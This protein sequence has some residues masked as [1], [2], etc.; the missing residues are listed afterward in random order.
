MDFDYNIFISSVWKSNLGGL[1][2]CIL[3]ILTVGEA[4]QRLGRAP[5]ASCCYTISMILCITLGFVSK[6][7]IVI[8]I[9]GCAQGFILAG[10]TSLTL[11]AVETY[12]TLIR[13]VR[14]V[15]GNSLTI[16]VSTFVLVFFFTLFPDVPPLGYWYVL[17]KLV[18]YLDQ[19]FIYICR[20]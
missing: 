17:V 3:A 9:G 6:D 14:N 5:V 11:F 8:W 7:E 20:W 13:Y 16:K 2:P 15:F 4:I 18:L 10:L 1:I 12:T 19:H